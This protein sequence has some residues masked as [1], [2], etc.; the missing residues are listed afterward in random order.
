M[1]KKV[2]LILCTF[3]ALSNAFFSVKA[4][5]DENTLYLDSG[6]AVIMDANTKR[7][8]YSYN[9]EDVH[10]PASIT[11]VMTMLLGIESGNLD[12]EVT[13]SDYGSLSIEVGSSHISI[14]PG[15]TMKLKD[16]I[17]ATCLVSANDGANMIAEG[18]S[19]DID[20]FVTLMNQRAKEIGCTN[21]NFTNPHGLHDAEHYTTAIDM[22]KIMSEACSNETYTSMTTLDE[23][24]IAPTNK[25]TT[26][27]YLYGQNKCMYEES[28]YYIPEVISAKSGYTDQ[29]M[30]TYVAYAKKGD[31]ELVVCV[32][33][34]TST[35]GMYTDLQ[36]LFEYGFENYSAYE[37][38]DNNLKL[39]DLDNSLFTTGGKLKL[40]SSFDT[41]AIAEAS[42]KNNF[43]FEYELNAEEHQ[44]ANVGDVVGKVNLTYNGE[45]IDSRNLIVVTPI[46]NLV[47]SFLGFLLN[48][49]KIIVIFIIAAIV[50]LLIAKKVYTKYKNEQIR[51]RRQNREK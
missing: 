19:G 23:Y 17:M 44:D 7:V 41:P 1:K 37:G 30:H 32:M 11:K 47:T 21:T 50:L 5:N 42:E 9:G 6:S 4:E 25:T 49:I 38:F 33:D 51:R 43:K 39:P 36:T 35:S 48:F 15:E 18:V 46:K 24:E 26:P 2:L 10:Y 31:V 34:C 8:L 45:V 40:S 16:A 27:R 3:L 28:E 29:A 12:R 13:I 22:A 20:T 14:M